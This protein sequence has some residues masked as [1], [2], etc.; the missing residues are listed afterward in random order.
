MRLQGNLIDIFKTLSKD[1]RLLR[2]LFYK[3]EHLDDDVTIATNERP[4]IL[5]MESSLKWDIIDK[6]LIPSKIYSTDKTDE[7]ELCRI[8]IYPSGRIE[9]TNR[10]I[11]NQ[12]I[13]FEV[14]THLSYG[15]DFRQVA[16]ADRLTELFY[17]KDITGIGQMIYKGM[18]NVNPNGLPKGYSGDMHYFEIGSSQGI[19]NDKKFR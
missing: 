11:A 4:N 5:D 19:T 8:L 17:E 18:N 14:L 12:M 9:S 15:K 10:L 1:E 7:V 3:A 16:I 2:L 6:V 13:T